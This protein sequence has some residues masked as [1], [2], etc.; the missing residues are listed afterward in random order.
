MPRPVLFL[1][2]GGVMNDNALR[3][4]QWQRLVGEF[5]PPLL[6]GTPDRWAEA[7]R[8]VVTR[9]W[10]ELPLGETDRVDAAYEA[11][12]RAYALAWLHGMCQEV[13]VPA[14]AEEESLG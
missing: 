3:G 9:L 1:D 4:P 13:G 7:N 11:F 8:I 14:P 12:K 2:D 6:G 5:F 10:E